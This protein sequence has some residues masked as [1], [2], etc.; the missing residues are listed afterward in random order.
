MVSTTEVLLCFLAFF[1]GIN[2]PVIALRPIFLVPP[3]LAISKLLKMSFFL[4][5]STPSTLGAVPT[6]AISGL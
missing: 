4:I 2:F 5:L 3:R 6:T 1:T